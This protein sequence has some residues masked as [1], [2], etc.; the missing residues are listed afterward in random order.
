[1]HEL[2][3]KSFNVREIRDEFPALRQQIYG[4]NLIY[5]DNG[6]T[7]Q[8][9]QLVLNAIN[10]FYSKENANIH[11]GVHYMSQKATTEYEAARQRIQR[12]IGARK[13]EE[14]IFTKGTTDSI[15]LV[16]FSFGHLLS[17]GDEILISAMEHHSN[18]VP[19]QMLCERQG[20]VLK[21][22]PINQR[23]EII[24]EAFERLLSPKTKLVSITHI[25]NTL[26]TVNP[27]KEIIQK[28]HAVG[29]KVF[30]DGAQSI[31]HMRI[32]VKEL[33]CDFYAFSSHKVFGPTGIGVLYG[34]EDLLDRMPP[35][36]GGGDMISRVTFERTTYNEL[37]FKF[38]AGTP[39][40]AG[41]ICLG[42]AFE[43]LE[44]IDMEAAERHERELAKYAEDM[45]DTFE[46]LQI[47]GEAK[48]KT[49]VVSFSVKGIHPFDI[50]TLLDKQGIAVRTGHHCTQPLMDFYAI[51]GTVR[52]SF[53][54]YNT[55][56]EIDTFVQ[57]VERSLSMLK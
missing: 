40:I 2:E 30:L 18:I 37:P 31:Q 8:K 16:A 32:N 12:Y 1:M 19:W 14:V 5:F 7:S 10:L 45:L 22:A 24:M 47:I 13:S 41:G 43:Y 46:G 55:K 49:S 23:G 42:K 35:Y 53:A 15:N 34:K 57:A 54:F 39:H 50:G 9:P 51:P 25:S 29:A 33:D 28:A 20:C 17:T 26:G 11:R 4:K 27:V 6:A 56:E 36:Q 38:E 44:S 48:D 52:A 21:V 3:K